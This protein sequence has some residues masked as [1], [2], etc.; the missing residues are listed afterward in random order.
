VH[1]EDRNIV[2]LMSLCLASKFQE[3]DKK[4]FRLRQFQEQLGEGYSREQLVRIERAIFWKV[5]KGD[6]GTRSIFS[7]ISECFLLGDQKQ[8]RGL[9][10][11]FLD[12]F[13]RDFYCANASPLLASAALLSL[14]REFLFK[15]S[16]LQKLN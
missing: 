10:L 7:S 2:I 5:L 15:K 6:I 9:S 3:Q 11:V 1:I 12:Y 14:S 16:Q 4:T 13:V 8:V